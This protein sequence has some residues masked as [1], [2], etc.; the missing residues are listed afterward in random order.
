ML[1][2]EPRTWLCFWAGSA[3]SQPL[4]QQH[5]K[6]LLLMEACWSPGAGLPGTGSDTPWG[7]APAAHSC[8]PWPLSFAHPTSAQ[9]DAVQW[10]QTV[11]CGKL[12]PNFSFC[13]SLG[14]TSSGLAWIHLPWHHCPRGRAH[15]GGITHRSEFVSLPPE[16][17]VCL[18]C[19]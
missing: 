19:G 16:H 4:I 6:V 14:S 18:G 13:C 12:Q 17:G 15:H 9:G 7:V 5:P 3:H 10:G 8:S 1:G 11:L 2:D